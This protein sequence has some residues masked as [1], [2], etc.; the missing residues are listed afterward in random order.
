MDEQYVIDLY[1]Q[2]L[3]RDP[4]PGGFAVN[5]GLLQ[6]G[7]ISAS[8]LAGAFRTSAEA[9]SSPIATP[10]YSPPPPPPPPPSLLS[11]PT[12][13]ESSDEQYLRNLYTQVLG[14]EPDPEGFASN[15]ALLQ[16]G[17]INLS[18]ITNAFVTS[19]EAQQNT[20]PAEKEQQAAKGLLGGEGI[21]VAERAK[22]LANEVYGL[23]GTNQNYDAQ[24]NELNSLSAIDPE[25][26]YEA[27][28]N[29][30][31]KQMGWQVGQNTS[32][33]N[34]KYQAELNS[35]LPGAKEAGL[36]NEE[37]N[38]LVTTGADQANRENQERIAR[39]KAK[40]E[41]WV[42][43]NIPGGF[44]TLAA[45]GAAIAAPYALGA[46][47][48]GAAGAGAAAGGAAAGGA[49][50]AGLSAAELL[51]VGGFVPTAGSA[52]SFAA[53]SLLGGATLA[54]G[55]GS[56]GIGLTGG[57]GGSTGLLGGTG[58]ATFGG[59][60]SASG[61]AATQAAAGLGIAGGSA[62]PAAGMAI[63]ALP[64]TVGQLSAALPAQGSVGG[65]GLGLS[66]ELA[67]GTILGSGLPGG[68][69]IGASYALGANGLPAT[70][71]LGQPIPA[72][73]IGISNIP[74]TVTAGLPDLA[75]L[76]NSPLGK[77]GLQTGLSALTGGQQQPAA[78]AAAT[79]QSI[80]PRGQVDYSGILNLLQ[81][82]SPQRNIYSLLG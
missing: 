5:L 28:I 15:L 75:N 41:G 63:G 1:R 59:A 70:N 16:S 23:Y 68:G 31:G 48:S 19:P 64:S 40:G 67:P 25:A 22:E 37:V 24:L 78:Q 27:R 46:L 4:D 72:S 61:I 73:S 33:E 49:A 39:E 74:E 77:V 21:N 55:V 57:A 7:A 14:R 35:L 30:L 43:Q 20:I 17:A 51:A 81:A 52:A 62:L 54:G 76:L 79:P 13:S 58:A 32:G 45:L 6:S 60:G 71:L 44:A 66:A 29:L 53:P 80:I 3:G 10:S 69:S 11:A 26:F 18:E 8:D 36:S 47:G 56:G 9:Q 34:V 12:Q 38:K 65:A 82:R 50:G 2:I 42:N